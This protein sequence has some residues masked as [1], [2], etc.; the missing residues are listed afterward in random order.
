MRLI[1]LLVVLVICLLVIGLWQGWF[2]ITS[3]P[4]TDPSDHKV[5]VGVSVDRDKMKADVKKAEEKVK[6]E[7]RELEG[8]RKAKE[9]K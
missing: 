2:S 9:A 6:E 3:S 4:S 1:K 8:K 5:N 7:V